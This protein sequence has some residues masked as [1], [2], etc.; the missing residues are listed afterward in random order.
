[1]EMDVRGELDDANIALVL[2]D[3]CSEI[4]LSKAPLD[5][6]RPGPLSYYGV[7]YT[8]AVYARFIEYGTRAAMD[9]NTTGMK[10][11]CKDK[12]F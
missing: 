8:D 12:R 6:K 4:G 10:E 1:M 7:V 2:D 11:A 5:L 3:I 9:S